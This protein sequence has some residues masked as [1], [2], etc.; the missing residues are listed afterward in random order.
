MKKILHLM[1]LKYSQLKACSTRAVL[2]KLGGRPHPECTSRQCFQNNY[3][4]NS[5]QLALLVIILTWWWGVCKFCNSWLQ[6]LPKVLPNNGDIIHHMFDDWCHESHPLAAP[7]YYCC[8]LPTASPNLDLGYAGS[9]TMLDNHYISIGYS[10][11]ISPLLL[12]Y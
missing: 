6:K 5:D 11:S 12:N 10:Q 1:G 2:S 9:K 3:L 4:L 8:S 7:I